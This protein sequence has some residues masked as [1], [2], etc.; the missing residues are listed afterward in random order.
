M[1]AVEVS[2]LSKEE[3][4]ELCCSYAALML[5]DEGLEVNVSL[6]PHTNFIQAEKLNKVIKASGNA[7]EPYWPMLFTKALK[8]ADI[9]EM[10][11]NVAQAAPAAGGAGPAAAA[12][13]E[14]APKE[15]KKEEEENV[16]M[17]GLFGDEDDY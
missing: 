17:G 2:K 15:E 8:T 9:G 11:T 14:E 10:L 4:D 12:V 1:A 13:T 7:V 16:D 5:H 6:S 3:H